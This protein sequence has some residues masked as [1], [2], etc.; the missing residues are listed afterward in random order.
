MIGHALDVIA[1]THVLN[2][3]ARADHH[4][5]VMIVIGSTLVSLL[6]KAKL[7]WIGA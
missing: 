5:N 7:R 6:K 4:T 3:V 2:F 1:L